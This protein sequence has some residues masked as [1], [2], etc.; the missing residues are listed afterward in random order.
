MRTIRSTHRRAAVLAGF[1]AVA[2]AASPGLTA[3]SSTS[4]SSSAAG[5][6]SGSASV[7]SVPAGAVYQFDDQRNQNT[8]TTTDPAVFKNTAVR[9]QLSDDLAKAVPAGKKLDVKSFTLT[10][11]GFPSGMCRTDIDIEYAPGGLE[12]LKS[13]STEYSYYDSKGARIVKKATVPE[14]VGLGI[15]V[16]PTSSVSAV[17]SDDSLKKGDFITEDFSH[18]TSVAQCGEEVAGLGFVY[19]PVNRS[20]SP[21]AHAA[22]QTSKDPNDPA[23]SVTGEVNGADIGVSGKWEPASSSNS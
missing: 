9:I 15:G 19:I 3:C 7:P 23:L 13:Y 6:S 11:K 2:R 20:T 8:D 21:F 4:S 5:N 12:V 17:P 22:V 18:I 16:G 14:R 1:T 10:T